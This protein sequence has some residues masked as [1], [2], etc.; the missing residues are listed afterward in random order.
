MAEYFKTREIPLN[1]WLGV[2]IECQATK[3]RI[4]HLREL[5]SSVRFLSCEP[6]IEDF[7]HANGKVLQGEVIQQMP[8]K[9]SV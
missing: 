6:L 7:K 8:L 9:A 4:D 5:K 2:T 3:S 1:V